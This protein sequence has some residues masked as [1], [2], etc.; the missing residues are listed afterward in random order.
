M[1]PKGII[2][3]AFIGILTAQNEIKDIDYS[4]S[5]SWG[6][7]LGEP[8]TADYYSPIDFSYFVPTQFT[9]PA[10]PK[11]VLNNTFYK[12][13]NNLKFTY[14]ESNNSPIKAFQGT[15]NYYYYLGMNV[16]GYGSAFFLYLN[17]TVTYDL[18]ELRLHVYS[19]HTFEGHKMDLELQLV[20]EKNSDKTDQSIVGSDE[21]NNFL[22]MSVLFSIARDKKSKFIEDIIEEDED[23]TDERLRYKFAF[24]KSLDLN[25][26]FNFNEPYY[27]YKGSGTTPFD[28][29]EHMTW[30]VNK[31]VEYLSEKQ[32]R[33]IQIAMMDFYYDSD[34]NSITY[35]HYPNGNS[36]IV[37][38]NPKTIITYV[39]NTDR[40]GDDV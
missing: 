16:S 5:L 23:R 30:L 34:N 9:F 19:E 20:H 21:L 13:I 33:Q 3:L 31:K 40:D 39:E 10:Y 22:T 25:Q 6:G 1:N 29:G 32:M 37:K 12:P 17:K 27:L 2:L 18:K 11:F 38:P 15:T 24:V 7:C 35:R 26:F 8:D 4:Q 28:C 14:L 36:R